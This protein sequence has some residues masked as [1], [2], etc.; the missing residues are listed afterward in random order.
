MKKFSATIPFVILFML[1]SLFVITLVA[2]KEKNNILTYSQFIRIAM[3]DE[4]TPPIKKV[5]ITNESDSATVIF[6]DNSEK[7][8]RIPNS[9]G[10]A[11]K[12][13]ADS[14]TKRAIDVEVRAPSGGSFWLSFL[15]SIIVPALFLIMLIFMIRSAQSGG[16]QA[17][18]FGK[19]RAKLQQDTKVK[20]TF[21][22]VAGIDESKQELQE[23]V[24]FLKTSE[25][26]LAIGAR[27]P[28]GVLLV[29]A[30]GTG[31]TLLAKAVAG[32]AGVPF[33]SISGSDFVEMFVGVGASRVR[34]LFEQAKKNAPCIVF[35]DEIDAVGRQR[36]AGLGGGHDEREQ[37]LNQLL[38][39]MD[40]FESTTG[41]IVLAATNRPDILDSALLRPG[42]F[43]R[44][45]VIDRPDI[46]G[47]EA[48]L[49]VHAKG[50]PLAPDVDL[51]ILA[52][53]TP[54][55]TGADLSNM[56]NEAALL[57]ARKNKREIY[58]DDMEQ[59]IDKVLAG[60]ERKS[61]II[62]PKDK[63]VTAYHEV[64]HALVAHFE[65]GSDPLHKVTIIPRG[66]ALGI[67]MTLPEEDHLNLSRSQLLA[68]IKVLLGGRVAEEVVFG[69]ITTGAQ[70]DLQKAT[71]LLRKMVTQF[72]M[73]EK[74]GP[75]TF[76]QTNEHVFLG[77]D[78]GHIRDYSEEIA[79]RID[80]EMKTIISK[81]YE[82][83]TQLL[84]EKRKHM[85]AIVQILLDKETI[86]KDE[87]KEIV[88][89][90]DN[91]TF[92]YQERKIE[93]SRKANL[94]TSANGSSAPSS[95]IPN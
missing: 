72:G 93:G 1:L 70:N 45:I 22:D 51:R 60:P 42:R 74:L 43:D 15:T 4:G 2:K 81:L 64:G 14:L 52:R 6:L 18:S 8:V 26:Y 34:D 47:R 19:S 87:F 27:I 78:F 92:I 75:M 17:M 7:T 94:E 63:E 69:D 88:E 66:M 30:P 33:F 46:A 35:V 10:K 44:Q 90:V 55:F 73:S 20:I 65:K 31:K 85:D 11:L 49:K 61:R 40:G 53:R 79:T 95:P 86:E 58:M 91:G 38:V 23:V 13:L 29:G 36:G 67:T 68:R 12:D 9:D 3:P 5:I 37:T 83:C 82:D 24:D 56:L 62:T 57:A 59:A 84:K 28:K 39:E 25:K 71:E 76:G 77:R 48:I 21:S 89:K 54:G 16:S 50:K 41:I 32:E 80:S